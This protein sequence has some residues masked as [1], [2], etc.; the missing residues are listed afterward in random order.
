[1]YKVTT[2]TDLAISIL[3]NPKGGE[4]MR[5]QRTSWLH[6]VAYA[7]NQL[8]SNPSPIIKFEANVYTREDG[9]WGIVSTSDFAY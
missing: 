3:V 2:D 7:F 9:T 4:I 8:D 5:S 6:K 1:M